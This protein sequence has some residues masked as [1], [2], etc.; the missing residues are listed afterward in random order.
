MGF[1]GLQL[2]WKTLLGCLLPLQCPWCLRQMRLVVLRLLSEGFPAQSHPRRLIP[3]LP[4]G[5]PGLPLP[6]ALFSSFIHYPSYLHCSFPLSLLFLF[7]VFTESCM[8]C[9]CFGLLTLRL[10]PLEHKL[11]EAARRGLGYL[12]HTSVCPKLFQGPS[13]LSTKP[14]LTNYF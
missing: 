1:A 7:K 14:T 13:P 2:F 8:F 4:V 10:S 3:S 6:S 9:R 11:S 5:A 12:L